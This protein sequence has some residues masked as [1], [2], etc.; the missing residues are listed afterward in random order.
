MKINTEVKSPFQQLVLDLTPRYGVGEARSISKILFEDVFNTKRPLERFFSED[1]AVLFLSMRKKLLLG[2]PLQ[3][4]IGMADFFGLRFKVTPD[5]LI[6]RAETEELVD[7]CLKYLKTTSKQ[8][9]NVLDIGTGS[10]CIP[11]TIKKKMPQVHVF[12]CDVSAAALDI[13]AQNAK[14]NTTEVNWILSDILDE[15]TWSLFPNFDLIVSNP[16]YIT[17]AEK[18]LMPAHVLDHE[19]A[20]AL[21]VPNERPLLFYE[22]ITKFALNK[23]NTRGKLIFECNEFYSE[24]VLQL[25]ENES[26]VDCINQNDILEKVRFAEGTK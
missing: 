20:L 17:L 21:F 13:A 19:P 26:F 23:L 25:L 6:P 18:N 14:L 16:P 1:E 12:A 9:I 7:L 4:V 24:Q 2:E 15:N 22:K 5:V 3:Y 11:I 8:S 10:G